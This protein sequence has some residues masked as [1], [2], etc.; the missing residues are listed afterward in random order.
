MLKYGLV[1]YSEVCCFANCDANKILTFKEAT[2]TIEYV[3][4]VQPYTSRNNMR[5]HHR[6]GHG[7]ILL[8]I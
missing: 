3:I 4:F 5:Y 2:K 1:T 7:S 8:W 6:V